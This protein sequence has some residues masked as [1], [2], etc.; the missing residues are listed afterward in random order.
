MNSLRP[1][2]SPS[3]A[4]KL[5]GQ[6]GILHICLVVVHLILCHE[7]AATT[8]PTRHDTRY[9]HSS[10]ARVYREASLQGAVIAT[11]RIAE[12]V[13]VLEES[14]LAARVRFMSDE[15]R[16]QPG[17]GWIHS[18]KLQRNRPA[19]TALLRAA[20]GSTSITQRRQTLERAT[21]LAPAD[22]GVIDQLITVL[23]S[24]RDDRAEHM[25]KKGLVA[26]KKRNASWDGPLYPTLDGLTFLPERC[27]D[28]LPSLHNSP[29]ESLDT[30]QLRARAFAIV[31]SGKVVSVTTRGYQ[32]QL[33]D[34]RAC[35]DGPCGRQAGY[36]LPRPST[37]GALVPSWM[38]AGHR[39]IGYQ[40]STPAALRRT[41]GYRS[42]CPTCRVFLDTAQ[43]SAIE[44]D[45]GRWRLLWRELPGVR[46]SEWQSGTH[47]YGRGQPMAR[48]D[49]QR[50]NI[51]LLWLAELE[52]GGC[53]N[54]RGVWLVRVP[55]DAEGRPQLAEEGRLFR[56]GVTSS[57]LA[58]GAMGDSHG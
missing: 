11:L 37:S 45:G 7:A 4:P 47:P 53:E 27:E 48:F 3:C 51:R 35:L 14:E 9:V 29:R 21:A 13:E 2:L 5:G 50:G 43:R 12:P 42:D 16:A 6:R 25:A 30:E 56:Q 49:E 36:V 22:E 44:L 15:L 31:D 38:V 17:E 20:Q 10:V 46:A 33:L 34:R 23:G 1:P 28:T 52:A 8:T 18:S 32:T 57:P 55:F 19:L 40:P 41:W 58:P 26:A 39:V 24:V 54:D